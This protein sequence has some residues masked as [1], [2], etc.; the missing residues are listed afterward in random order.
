[1]GYAKRECIWIVIGTI[2]MTIG[3]GASLAAPMFVGHGVDLMEK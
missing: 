3:Q 1:M 2:M